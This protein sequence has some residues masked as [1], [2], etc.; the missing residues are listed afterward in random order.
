MIFNFLLHSQLTHVNK[1]A[2]GGIINYQLLVIILQCL[3][4]ICFQIPGQVHFLELMPTSQ[5]P[6]NGS[7][8]VCSVLAH[9]CSP[10]MLSLQG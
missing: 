8:H 4:Y 6:A 5:Y 7:S 10:I 2:P 1:K 9:R 3:F